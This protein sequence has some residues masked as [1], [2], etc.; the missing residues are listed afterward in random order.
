MFYVRIKKTIHISYLFIWI[1]VSLAYLLKC[2]K[3]FSNTFYMQFS[4]NTL[5]HYFIFLLFE[6]SKRRNRMHVCTILWLYG[7]RVIEVRSQ[8]T[9]LKSIA[10]CSFSK[11]FRGK[12]W[13]IFQ[14]IRNIFTKLVIYGILDFIR[15]I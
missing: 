6:I 15:Y 4:F 8:S 1:V 3:S 2:S 9:F 10:K 7:Y 14:T 5:P 11:Y 12:P 13:Q